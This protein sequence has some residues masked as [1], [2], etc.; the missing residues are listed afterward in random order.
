MAKQKGSTVKSFEKPQKSQDGRID[1]KAV[2]DD[3]QN[4][5]KLTDPDYRDALIA[6]VEKQRKEREELKDKKQV[7]K[8]TERE[9]IIEDILNLAGIKKGS[10]SE[11]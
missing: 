11:K 7:Q 6:E 1:T 3:S 5:K 8:K 10:P 9:L 2:Y 4:K